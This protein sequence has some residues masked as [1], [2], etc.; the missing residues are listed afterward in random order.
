MGLLCV[1]LSC[2]AGYSVSFA[3]GL[4]ISRLH[5]ILPFMIV[6]IGV[7]DM[8]V[9]VNTIDQT[10][11]HLSA[12]ERFRIGMTHAG[13]SI[14]ITSVTNA[15]A[16]F[17]GSMTKLAALNSFCLFAGI[18]VTTL[19][20]AA[21]AIF[22]PWFL[23]DLRRQ[24]ALKGDFCGACCCKEDSVLCCQGRFLS[25]RQREFSGLPLEPIAQDTE[26]S[27][28]KSPTVESSSKNIND[29]KE[30]EEKQISKLTPIEEESKEDEQE[31][32]VS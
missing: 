27:D 6:G 26:D 3:A 7:D 13:P 10:P 12:N 21:L 29:K 31:N 5:N 16:F 9:I 11:M 19:Y 15:I 22:A 8:F 4:Q 20:V 1:I 18:T 28:E 2:S 17:T 24:H 32:Y 23:S 25:K 30:D 14:T